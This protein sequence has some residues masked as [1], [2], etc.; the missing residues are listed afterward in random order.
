M[1]NVLLVPSMLVG[2]LSH[3]LGMCRVKGSLKKGG[4]VVVELDQG[5]AFHDLCYA[6]HDV[7]YLFMHLMIYATIIN[8]GSPM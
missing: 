1:E 8:D 7:C 4:N 6:F 5:D 2:S 3:G